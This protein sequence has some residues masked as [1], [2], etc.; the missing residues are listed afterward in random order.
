MTKQKLRSRLATQSRRLEGKMALTME[1]EATSYLL[2]NG[3]LPTDDS[4]KYTWDTPVDT[5]VEALFTYDGFQN[6]ITENLDIFGIILE[7]SPFYAEAGGQVADTGTLQFYSNEDGSISNVDVIDVQSYAGFV[8]HTCIA[9]NDDNIIKSNISVG[10][11]VT[12]NVDYSRRRKVAPNHTM[13][14]ILNFALREVIGEDVD[15]KGS[16]VSEDKFRFDFNAKKALTSQEI[17]QVETIINNIVN[18]ELDVN[19]QVVSLKTAMDIN[20]LR[21]VFGETYPD[22]VRVV[23]VGPKIDNLLER[24]NDNEWK[25]SSIEFCGGTHIS[26]TKDAIACCLLEETAVAKG[27][28]RISGITG[29]NAKD[30]IKY[31]QELESTLSL[32]H[33]RLDGKD[34]TI[35]IIENQLISFRVDLDNADI[36]QGKKN[37]LRIHMETLAKKIVTLKN[38]AMIANV[39]I[40]LEG[41]L[42]EV[43]DIVGR[44]EKTAVLSL[45]IGSD[46][47]AI[48]RTIDEIKKIDTN[49]SFIGISEDVDAGKLSIFA[50][51]S[52]DAQTKGMSA[53]DWITNSIESFG[54]RGGGRPNAAQGSVIGL[55][56]TSE[57]L[58]EAKKYLDDW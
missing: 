37:Q 39:N 31:S 28:R 13:T 16:L 5:K 25:Y 42:Q 11:K 19:S 55:S 51:V 24:P 56:T 26:N 15:Q 1:A 29:H 36:S 41:I 17:L 2:N 43:K 21:A 30:A 46:S 8:L 12:A 40:A 23:S 10:D 6:H 34:T 18:K 27:I 52:D 20:G 45:D 54:G 58:R 3:I 22:P 57:I 38:E 49:L 48:K 50:I 35:D 7:S 33:K 53:K 9:S 44:G 14:H 32:I 4:Y 47:K